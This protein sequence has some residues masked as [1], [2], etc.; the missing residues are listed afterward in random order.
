MESSRENNGPYNI[1]TETETVIEFFDV[2]AMQVVWHGNYLRYFETGRRALLEKIDYY[3]YEMVKTNY[4]FPVIDVSV[5]YINPLRFL[6]RI[7][8][9]SI[10]MEYE[11]R[12]KIKYEI[13]NAETGVLATKGVSTQ[14][15]F[16]MRTGETCF[17]CP[18]LLI[19]KVETLIRENKQ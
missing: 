4:M 9:K 10:L 12:L 18:K 3:Y 11:N 17:V 1:F 14:M 6:N 7:I 5:K 8:I 19:E 16:D 15:A 2:D 13:R